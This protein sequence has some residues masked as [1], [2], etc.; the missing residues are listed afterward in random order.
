[1][2]AYIVGH[3]KIGDH[4]MK[5][6]KLLSEGAMSECGWLAEEMTKAN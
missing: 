3:Q 1:M 4:K 2:E 5:S 6:T